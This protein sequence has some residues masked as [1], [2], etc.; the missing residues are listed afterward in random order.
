MDLVQKSIEYMDLEKISQAKMATLVGIGES[1]ISRWL[2]GNYP[3]PETIDRKI[4]AFFEKENL[5]SAQIG[6]KDIG[7]TMTNISKN[8]WDVLEYVR[9]RRLVGTVYG[10]AGIGKTRTLK[11]W[12]KGKPDVIVVTASPA[13]SNPKP[14][15]KLLARELKT[16]RVGGMDD[17]YLDILDKLQGAD[18]TIV[19]DEAQH[20]NRRT[21]EQVRD[22]NDS[23]ETAIILIG[24]E[25]IYSKMVGKQQAEFAQLFSRI[26]IRN[27]LLTDMFTKD[28]VKMVFGDGTDDVVSFL[29]NICRSKYGLRGA[30]NVFINAK[31]NEDVTQKGLKAM[32]KL[33]G[34]LV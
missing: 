7:F 5:R 9:L 10:D 11:E 12:A 31:N 15:C 19:I 32:A 33:M 29:H 6:T 20:L 26:G 13:F 22:I 14:F 28:D 17:I 34:I 23:T 27:H 30:I 24:N 16:I 1:T 25:I 2:K 8:V 4:E 21:L 18:K 3:N